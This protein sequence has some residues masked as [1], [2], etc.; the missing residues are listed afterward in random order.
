MQALFFFLKGI[1]LIT[2]LLKLKTMSALSVQEVLKNLEGHRQTFQQIHR[3]RSVN[4]VPVPPE[5]LQDM[6]ERLDFLLSFI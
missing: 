3:D 2:V 5:Q 4:G 6:A 1:A